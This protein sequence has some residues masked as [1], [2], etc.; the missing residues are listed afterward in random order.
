MT[1]NTTLPNRSACDVVGPSA[2]NSSSGFPNLDILV[3]EDNPINRKV[4]GAYLRKI[5]CP[6]V[7][8]VENGS[9]AVQA[10]EERMKSFDVIFMGLFMP[11]MDGFTATRNIRRIEIE[12]RVTQS[13]PHPVSSAYIV[14]LSRLLRDDCKENAFAAGVNEYLYQPVQFREVKTVLEQRE[15][16]T[17]SNDQ[18]DLS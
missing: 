5:N 16:K 10:V 7:Q 9:L 17:P 13:T 15:R 6:S 2:D 3:V 12:R 4:L 8:L 14:A 1:S 18:S 11:V